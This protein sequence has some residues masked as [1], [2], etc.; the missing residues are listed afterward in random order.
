MDIRPDVA[1][2]ERGGELLDVKPEE[3]AVGET[4]VIKPGESS[5]GWRGD[6]GQIWSLDTVALT[7]E[8]CRAPSV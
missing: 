6:G 7:G 3:V 8:V 2:V 1:H 4:V 5:D